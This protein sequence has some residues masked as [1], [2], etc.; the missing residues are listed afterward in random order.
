MGLR[1]GD[2]HIRRLKRLAGAGLEREIGKALYAGAQRVQV[3][4]QISITKGSA[5]GR[6]TKK[7]KHVPSAPG[8][9][10]NNDEGTLAN[11]IE[12]TLEFDSDG[13]V[14]Q[15]SSNAAH[16]SPLEFGT[17]KMAARPFMAPARDAERQKVEDLVVRAV[18]R[19]SRGR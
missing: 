2:A 4:A 9:P 6:K 8:Q 5:S 18:E 1:G 16:S 10:P 13:P 11:N 7:H 15:V 19:L 14:A 17:S 3:A 12:T